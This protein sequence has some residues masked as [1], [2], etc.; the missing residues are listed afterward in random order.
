MKWRLSLLVVVLLG[1]GCKGRRA[2]PSGKPDLSAQS[3]ARLS[4]IRGTLKL[5]GLR[6]PVTVLRDRWGVPH[7]YAQNEHD[8]FFAQG[9]VAAQ[10]RLFQMELWKRSGQGRLAEVLG[11]SALPRDVYAR[12]LQYRGNMQAEY[13]S[14]SPDTQHILEAFTAGI[15]AYI[16]HRMAPGGKGLPV[17]FRIA[18]FK[19][20]PWR[21]SD[22]LNRMAA[23][24]MMNNAIGELQHAQAVAALGVTQA[25]KL[26]AL[27]PHVKF[28]PA[29]GLSY[30]GLS[31]KLLTGL[32]GTDTRIGF[33]RDT[34][35]GSNDWAVSGKMTETGKPLLANDPHRVLAEPS[36][37][38]MVHLVAPGWDV[39]GAGE[40]ALPGVAVGHNRHIAW[41]FTIFGEDQEDFYVEQLNPRDPLEYKTPHGWAKMKVVRT[42]FHVRGRPDVTMDLKFTRHGPVL[43]EDAHRALALRWIGAEPGTA[44]YLGALAVDRA[45]NWSE[46]KAAT[47][48]WKVPSENLVYAD[49]QGNI[50]MYSAGLA[51]IRKNW[52]GL[53]PL[54]GAGNYEWSG[55][56]PDADLP[57]SFNQ[58][59]RWCLR[60]AARFTASANQRMI[61]EN[62]PY[63]IGYIWAPGFRYR[64]ILQ[65]LARD[66]AAGRKVGVADME[67]LQND[68]A[69]LPARA[70]ISLLRQ[71]IGPH[72]TPTQSMLASWDGVINKGAAPALYEL[73]L[74]ALTKAVRRRVVPDA[75]K[76]VASWPP[77]L[78]LRYLS[79]PKTVVFGSHPVQGRNQVMLATLE[80]ARARLEKLEGTDPAKWS[81]GEIHTL[82]F[83][84]PLDELPGSKALLDAGPIP[85]PGDD[86]TVNAQYFNGPGPFSVLAG[87]SYKEIFSLANWDQSVAINV[88]GES[89]QPG[90]PY[91]GNLLPLWRNGQ[92]FPLAYSK[93]AV[94]KAAAAKLV[95]KP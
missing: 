23:F 62:Y 77:T 60:P 47:A 19:P 28:D 25:D 36:L 93:A 30:A 11:P 33:P 26:F 68:Q 9:Y 16:A 59:C 83:R 64:R 32:V 87:S 37:R 35:E 69:S 24:S 95:L 20:E 56:I 66:L 2:L 22:C 3:K 42:T 50:G 51:P 90:S 65:V 55:F 73:W 54:P 63:N 80:S 31:P 4:T 48:S 72:P 82:T 91:Y 40:P 58:E 53:L 94:E 88:P 44:G 49:T 5:A 71:A 81:W 15:N 61:P 34:L 84:H 52:T 75:D 86:Y 41:G 13:A 89:G 57:H 14:Y 45:Q 43:W 67:N 85:R 76:V 12:L 78:L 10:D 17:E 79:H 74:Q 1:A 46:F 6:Q 29:P 92:Y 18:G 70:L 27:D 21:P 38:Y 8:L 39:E 7:I